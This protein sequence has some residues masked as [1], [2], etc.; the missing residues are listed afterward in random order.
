MGN[1]RRRA[2]VIHPG[3][4]RCRQHGTARLTRSHRQDPATQSRPGRMHRESRRWRASRFS[5]VK[6]TLIEQAADRHG[7][8]AQRRSSPA[9]WVA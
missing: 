4:A 9:P 6:W 3:K 1:T 7:E 2:G 8:W 5:D